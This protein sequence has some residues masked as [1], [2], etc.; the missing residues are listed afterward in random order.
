MPLISVIVP[1]YNTE[2]FLHRCVESILTQSFG[3]FEILLVDDGSTDRSGFI[4]D[5]YAE[6]DDRI[7]VLHQHNQGQ[8]AARNNGLDW[9]FA[10]SDSSYIAFVD[11]DDWIHPKFF[12]FLLK[13]L[14]EYNVDMC[15]C[16]H[17]KT[18]GKDTIPYDVSVEYICVSPEEQY[19]H[20]YSP[21]IW[22]KLYKRNVWE[23]VRFP[24]GQ[25]FEDLAMWYKLLFSQD[26]IALTDTALYYYYMNPD[27][28]VHQEWRLPRMAR[29][30][31]WDAQLEFFSHQ[32]NPLVE[33]VVEHYSTVCKEEF[34]LIGES[35]E[36]SVSEK[37][38]YQES[39]AERVR[40]LMRDFRRPLKKSSNY[41]WCLEIMHPFFSKCYWTLK[42]II[43]GVK[44]KGGK[45]VN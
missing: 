12:E 30:N 13:G 9:V 35:S 4:C 45:D 24:E 15:Q 36:I 21:Y 33:T 34:Y 41:R 42:G 28:T 20:H 16:S 43:E 2:Q 38:N 32:S 40:M 3:D 10:N 31:A 14:K 17:I 23:T 26:R 6:K 37:E 8:G 5:E 29:M 39:I 1:V 44:S 18:E 27:S 25:I 11:S 22:E 19:I 7:N